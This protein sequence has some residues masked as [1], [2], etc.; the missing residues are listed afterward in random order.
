MLRDMKNTYSGQISHGIQYSV[1]KRACI[2]ETLR[3]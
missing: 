1:D 2:V 3:R